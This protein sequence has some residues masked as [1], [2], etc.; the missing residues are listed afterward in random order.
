MRTV[1]RR[2]IALDRARHAWEGAVKA[3]LRQHH[4]VRA[5]ARVAGVSA[6]TVQRIAA[7]R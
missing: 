4:S 6:S 3:A 5:V 7:K 2:R 1:E